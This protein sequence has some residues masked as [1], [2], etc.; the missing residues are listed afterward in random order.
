MLYK[1]ILAAL[2][3]L[4]RLC[5]AR[6]SATLNLAVRSEIDYSDIYVSD[7]SI[8][9]AFDAAGN[10]PLQAW[11]DD[12]NETYQSLYVMDEADWDS[13][14]HHLLEKAYNQRLEEA[15]EQSPEEVHE[16]LRN[17]AHKRLL[18]ALGSITDT[19]L[20]RVDTDDPKTWICNKNGPLVSCTRAHH[21]L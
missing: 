11:K 8:L 2:V 13:M 12:N 7:V 4:N 9:D 17:E 1:N 6:P 5:Y 3:G 16:Q 21:C 20:P 14:H 19:L 15:F 10:G 18:E